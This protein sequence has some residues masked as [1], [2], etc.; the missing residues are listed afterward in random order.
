MSEVKKVKD[1]V[2]VPPVF[3]MAGRLPTEKLV[4]RLQ[5][6]SATRLLD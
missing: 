2:W 4:G 6:L 1:K 5:K 3:P